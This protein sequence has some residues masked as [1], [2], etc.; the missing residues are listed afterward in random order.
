MKHGFL[1]INKP[2]GC[3]S[4]DIV[5]QIRRLLPER[6][7]GHLGTLDPEASGL[8]VLAVGA[9]ALKVVEF[10]KDLGKEYDAE[11]TFG[12]V[13]TT[14]DK[15]G[16]IEQSSAKPGWVP[17]TIEALAKIIQDKFSGLV[18]QV[19]PAFSAVHIDGKR[20][21]ELARQGKTLQLEPRSVELHCG[22]IS[23]DYPKLSLHV[24][25]SSGTYVRS[26]ANDLG[27]T[28]RCGGYLSA[29][30]RTKVGEWKLEDAVIPEGATWGHILPLKDVLKS[31]PGIDVTDEEARAISFGQS[32][33]KEVKADTFAW[34]NGLPIAV[35]I[36]Q[37]DGTRMARAR[38][39][40]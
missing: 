24:H 30:R 7:V 17:P 34:N 23:Y 1:L 12:A 28:L 38:K 10:F 25:C 37:K 26:L 31:F 3:T 11:I 8:L 2:T 13:S 33:N 18:D 36:P 35:L 9:K 29:L 21:H 6:N 22:I 19:P 20:A 40:F 4:H 15:E 5:H 39:V 27:A 14:Y 32:I 16:V